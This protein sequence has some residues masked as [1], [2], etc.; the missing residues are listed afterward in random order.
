MPNSGY[1]AER[2]F[3]RKSRKKVRQKQTNSSEKTSSIAIYRQFNRY[4]LDILLI[5]NIQIVQQ[6]EIDSSIER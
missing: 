6:K 1:E 3:D 4:R 5:R 2:Q